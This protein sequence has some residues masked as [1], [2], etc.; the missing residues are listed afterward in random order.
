MPEQKYGIAQL[1]VVL[2]GGD[3]QRVIAGIALLKA[4]VS[5]NILLT[6]VPKAAD[7]TGKLDDYR[8]AYLS[9]AGIQEKSIDIDSEAENSWQEIRLI[10]DYLFKKGWNTVFIVSDPPHMKRLDWACRRLLLPAGIVYRLV[11]TQ[12]AWWNPKDWW[13]NQTARAFVCLEYVK[14][15]YYNLRYGLLVSFIA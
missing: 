10:R 3:E 14:L 12:P 15:L 5:D 13:K 11:A 2:G 6:G 7:S 9:A 4:G 1:V 8:L